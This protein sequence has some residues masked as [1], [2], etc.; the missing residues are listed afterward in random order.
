M[1]HAPARDEIIKNTFANFVFEH[2]EIA[3]YK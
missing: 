2:F 3:A 1:A